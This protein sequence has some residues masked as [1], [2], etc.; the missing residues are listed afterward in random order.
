MRRLIVPTTLALI[1]A[2]APTVQAQDGGAGQGMSGGHM[3]RGAGMMSRMCENAD[4]RLA[5]RLAFTEK[6]LNIGDAQ[7]ESWQRFTARMQAAQAPMK[8][9]CAQYAN[10]PMPAT[11][12]DRLDRMDQMMVAGEA[13]FKEVKTAVSELYAVLSPDQKKIADGMLMGPMGRRHP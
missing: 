12:P 1:I 2:L 6:K 11:L 13:S 8:A 10:A 4:A 5:G 9:A 7:R 3:M